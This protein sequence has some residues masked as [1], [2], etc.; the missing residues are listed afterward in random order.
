MANG[1]G[2]VY[3]F[4]SYYQ[5]RQQQQ[6]NKLYFCSRKGDSFEIDS[7]MFTV[8]DHECFEAFTH[9]FDL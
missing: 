1:M 4:I 6:R 7:I 5:S 2:D 8:F 3:S 9:Y